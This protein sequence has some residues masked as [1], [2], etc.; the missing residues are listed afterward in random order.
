MN[1]PMNTYP[2]RNNNTERALEQWWQARAHQEAYLSEV[3]G[4]DFHLDFKHLLKIGLCPRLI[5]PVIKARAVIR[6]EGNGV[7]LF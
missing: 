6:L 1:L 4:P 3:T 7:W 2:K 5:I